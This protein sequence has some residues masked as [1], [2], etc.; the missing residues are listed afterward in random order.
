MEQGVVNLIQAAID[1]LN[2][3][4]ADLRVHL[5]TTPAAFGGG[6]VWGVVESINVGIQGIGYGLLILFFLMSFFKTTSNFKDISLQQAIGWIVRFILVKVLIDYGIQILN[7]AISISMGVN[8]SILDHSGAFEFAS[9]PQEVLDAVSAME[10]A[11]WYERIGSFFQTIP[12][13]IVGGLGMLVIWVCGIIMVVSVYLRFF[14]VYIYSALAPIPLSTFGGPETS[15]TGKH[16]LKA[17]AA[18][19]LEICVIALAIVIFNAMVSS[20][21]LIFP[22]WGETSGGVNAEFWNTL[23]NYIFQV[24]LQTIMLV[25]VVMSANKYIREII[26]VGG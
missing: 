21:N 6:G 18:V 4:F 15:S 16:F 13:Y 23:M 7:F 1:F 5:T 24:G 25:I 2:N 8:D 17:Y 22:S 19:C 9:M 3:C 14:K 12:M 10:N 11:A 20:N 26:G